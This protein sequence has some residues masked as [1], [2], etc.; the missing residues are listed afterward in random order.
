MDFDPALYGS[1]VA[2]ILALKDNGNRLMPLDWGGARLTCEEEARRLLKVSP[3]SLF[4]N[5]P[6]PREAMT[7][8]WQYFDCFEEAH[9]LA[10][11]C[12]TPNG[13]YWHAIVHR[14]E[15]DSANAAYWF[16]KTGAH[17]AYDALAVEA[18]KI[19]DQYTSDASTAGRGLLGRSAREFRG[20]EW[21]PFA[22]VSFCDSARRQPG[23]AQERIAMEIQR[24]EWRILFDHCAA[25][26][27]EQGPR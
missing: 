2:R 20:G 7:G 18:A 22:F 23:S 4:P 5:A 27:P 15:G 16:R 13:Y 8:L 19:A 1:K 17:P 3:T 11:A 24:A 26:L 25:S 10:D 6:E 14:R 21:D 9:Q 12:E